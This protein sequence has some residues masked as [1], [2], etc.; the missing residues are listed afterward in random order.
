MSATPNNTLPNQWQENITYE[1]GNT[2]IYGN[3]IFKSLQN[4]NQGHP[5]TIEPD[6]I[7]WEAL[8]IYKKDSTVMPH[9]DY[10]G[11]ENFWDRDQLYIDDN[12]YVYINN[13]NTGINV[14]G[15]IQYV[16]TE[17]Q[18]NQIAA[19]AARLVPLGP[20]GDKGDQGEQG[21]T[22]AVEFDEL[23]PAQ[24]AQLKGDTGAPG[25]D[26]ESAY[27]IWLDQGHTGDEETFLE[28]LRSMA[29]TLDT[30]LSATSPNA[31]TNAA[32]TNAFNTYQR[33]VN[34]LVNNLQNR[35]I[36]LENRLKAT[37][38]GVENQFRFGITTEGKYGYFISGTNRIVPF[39]VGDEEVM[40]SNNAELNSPS[41]FQ[42]QIGYN[43]EPIME[44]LIDTQY[45]TPTG[46]RGT[47]SN[48]TGN[49]PTTLY[50]TG[51]NSL[52]LNQVYNLEKYIYYNK[53]FSQVAPYNLYSMNYSQQ[54]GLTSKNEESVEG[55]Y[56]TPDSISQISSSITI[57]V[58]PV[59]EGE[60]IYYQI[61][62]F[63]DS[64]GSL[65]T[66]VTTGAYRSDYTNGSFNDVTTITYEV[67][68]NYG[69]YFASYQQGA[70]KIN[71]IYIS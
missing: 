38:N 20:K 24:V 16:F 32:I 64:R 17:E 68:Y 10:S 54:N 13:E 23:T 45:M 49:D 40:A 46:L 58:E 33:Q 60:T 22:G 59:N 55:I 27:Q 71:S 57:E 18:I 25:A 15:R 2:V 1:Y 50:A 11:D 44:T 43:G 26:G 37:Y 56:F 51:V 66:L 67:P 69:F 29:I 35:V 34:T 31:L 70:Y 41:V 4:D 65:P 3:I 47:I 7:W 48:D 21:P 53:R 52:N 19:A 39:V 8:D 30:D 63:T 42:T 28:W 6:N 61:G 12:G 9:G 14:N 36:D 5:P 62:K